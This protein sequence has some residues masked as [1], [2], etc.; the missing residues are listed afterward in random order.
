M[1]SNAL[2]DG[3]LA[4]AQWV[5]SPNYDERPGACSPELLVIHNISLP[6]GCFGGNDIAALFCNRL[7][8]SADPFYAELDG[9]RVSSHLLIDRQGA[10]TQFVSLERRAWHAGLSQ[11][12]GRVNCND[13]SIGIELE[14]TDTL[15]YTLAQYHC[16]ARTIRTLREAMPSLRQAAIVGHSDIAPGRKTDPGPAFD[17]ALLRGALRE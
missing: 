3:R 12:C 4:K 5:P 16:L 1:T 14:G 9:L 10:L 11:W 17:W 2:I 7:D 13:Y 8:L 15:P 6:P